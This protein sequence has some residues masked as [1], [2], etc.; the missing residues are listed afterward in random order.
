MGAYLQDLANHYL[1]KMSKETGA[2]F[3]KAS[4]QLDMVLA[5][6][7]EYGG[8]RIRQRAAAISAFEAANTS[9][10]WQEARERSA[11]QLQEMRQ[12]RQQRAAA[13]RAAL[14]AKQA[15]LARRAR[16]TILTPRSW[17]VPI[18]AFP[19]DPFA[20]ELPVAQLRPRRARGG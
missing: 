16:E 20:D 2:E 10:L 15:A 19:E 13:R 3:Q 18:S 6:M 8:D 4:R 1:T 12:A 11:V 9:A 17:M 7:D 5:Q 14:W